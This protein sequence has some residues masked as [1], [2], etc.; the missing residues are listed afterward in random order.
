[1]GCTMNHAAVDNEAIMANV[2]VIQQKCQV[3]IPSVVNA[4]LLHGNFNECQR[5]ALISIRT[6]SYECQNHAQQISNIIHN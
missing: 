2:H 1:M 5:Q 6:M 4:L 3:G